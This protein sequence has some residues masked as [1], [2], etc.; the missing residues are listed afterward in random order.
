MIAIFL[1]WEVA[2]LLK[3]DIVVAIALVFPTFLMILGFEEFA[4][5]VMRNI[6]LKRFIKKLRN[7]KVLP[8]ASKQD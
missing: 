1:A 3:Q 2:T 7:R 5:R 4:D 8:P 6:R